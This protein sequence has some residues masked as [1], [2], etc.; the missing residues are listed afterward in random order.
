MRRPISLS[1][2]GWILSPL[3]LLVLASMPAHAQWQPWMLG[4][5]EKPTTGN[6]VITPGRTRTFLSP[7]NDSVVHWEEFATF[8]PAAVVQGWQGLRALPRR[9]RERRAADRHPHVAHRAGR[10]Q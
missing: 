9:G 8:N 4:P 2:G 1:R 5:F 7:M 6:P 10:E 3:L